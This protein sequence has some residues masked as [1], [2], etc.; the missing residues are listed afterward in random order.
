MMMKYL[1]LRLVAALVTVLAIAAVLPAQDQKED[2]GEIIGKVWE[3]SVRKRDGAIEKRRI[4]ATP[5]G[6]VRGRN[7]QEVGTWTQEGIDVTMRLRYG[8]D[9]PWNGVY[10]LTQVRKDPPSWKGVVRYPNGR[11]LA[12]PEVLLLKD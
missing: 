8:R 5:D 4:S 9:D 3:L 7:A 6:K 2:E 1:G 10:K 12:I 11:E